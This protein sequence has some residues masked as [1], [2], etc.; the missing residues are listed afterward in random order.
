MEL[1]HRAQHPSDIIH[2]QPLSRFLKTQRDRLAAKELD[3]ATLAGPGEG[4]TAERA[5]WSLVARAILN[6]DEAVTKN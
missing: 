3:P 2:A 4:D 6:L 5:A 1:H